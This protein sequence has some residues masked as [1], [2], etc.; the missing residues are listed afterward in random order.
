MRKRIFGKKL[1]RAQ[2]GRRAL[3]RSLVREFVLRGEIETTR[4]RGK[5]IKPVIDK[6][7]TG[8][9][10]GRIEDKRRILAFFMNQLEI[11][12]RLEKKAKDFGKRTSGFTTQVALGPRRGD[13][14][15][16]VRISW[17]SS[18]ENQTAE[19]KKS[20]SGKEGGVVATQ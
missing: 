17:V 15:P 11:A 9:K 3:L 7:I 14:T 13:R 16:V 10:K 1:S 18:P 8:A 5:L 2:K 4:S 20:R 19:V 12:S 6:L